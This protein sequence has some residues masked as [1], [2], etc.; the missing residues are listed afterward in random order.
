M[1]LRVGGE[2]SVLAQIA[3]GELAAGLPPQQM[4]DLTDLLTAMAEHVRHARAVAGSLQAGDDPHPFT[5]T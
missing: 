1:L 5:R 2:G 3:N 4:Q